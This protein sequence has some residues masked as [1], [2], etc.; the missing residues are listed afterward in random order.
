MAKLAP[1]TFAVYAKDQTRFI[2]NT[3]CWVL[4]DGIFKAGVP[5]ELRTIAI[6]LAPQTKLHGCGDVGCEETSVRWVVSNVVKDN[7]TRFLKRCAQIY[8]EGT[9]MTET[10]IRYIFQPDV[11]FWINADGTIHPNGSKASKGGWWQPKTTGVRTLH[12]TE[13][14]EAYGISLGVAVFH[15]VTTTRE[16]G[17]TVTYTE[18]CVNDTA[19]PAIKALNGWTGLNSTQWNDRAVRE[20]PYT[21]EAAVFLHNTMLGLCRVAQRFDNFFCDPAAVALAANKGLLLLG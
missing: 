10:V 3:D 4:P 5:P 13:Q 1:I 12:A 14:T 6:E 16:S 2:V 11:S 17:R 7:L 21:A 19:D 18:V 15:K 9:T 8:I 20:M